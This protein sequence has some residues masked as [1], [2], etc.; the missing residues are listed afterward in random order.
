MEDIGTDRLVVGMNFDSD[1]L[2]WDQFH[3]TPTMSVQ[4][5]QILQLQCY[6]LEMG[7]I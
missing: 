4:N 5:K 7:K 3:R 6:N 1:E 2:L